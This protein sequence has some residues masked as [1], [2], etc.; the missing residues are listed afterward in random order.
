[1]GDI[2]DEHFDR[3][4]DE[5]YDGGGWGHGLRQAPQC[6]R[7][8]SQEVHWKEAYKPDGSRGWRLFNDGN[9]RPHLCASG[10]APSEAAFGVVPE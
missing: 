2:A 9:N 5:G 3:M 10:A 6:R 4:M 1:M 8:R 7:C